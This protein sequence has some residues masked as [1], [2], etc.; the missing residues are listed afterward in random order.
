MKML[1]L[2]D[3]AIPKEVMKGMKKLEE[4]GIEVVYLDD[5]HRQTP[6]DITS[7]L[8]LMETQGA[9]AGKTNP[10]IVEA[11]KDADII[12]THS[13]SVNSDVIKAA[14]NLKY[15]GI[16]RNGTQNANTQL[17][18]ELGIQVINAPGRNNAAVADFTV[19]L[20]LAESRNIARGHH[21]LKEGEW[22]K[23][24]VNNPYVHDM[25]KTTIGIIGA[26]QIGSQV[27]RRLQ[28][29]EPRIIVHDPFLSDEQL[30]SM[31]YE[32]VSESQLL[33]EADF[34]SIHLRMTEKTANYFNKEKFEQMK[35]T[36]YFI[37]TSRAGMV[38]EDDLIEA[39]T[40]KTIG[41]AAIDVF[42]TEPLEENSP[43]LTLDNITITPHMAGY[44][45]D[46]FSNSVEIN[47]E[48]FSEVLNQ[49]AV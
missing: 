48:K 29:F 27:I 39:L 49:V 2:C 25:R 21:A 19:A 35:P 41:G 3:L 44:S 15:V 16:L 22:R 30:I 26:G 28:G 7:E 4:F 37:N 17:C 43:F 12:I 20:M 5:A 23:I 31:G 36:A 24:F 45:V 47:V 33:Q 8:L 10:E 1:C 32:P 46:A 14:K 9:D 18:E 34:V 11:A 6:E 38:N 42:S 13:S 40:N